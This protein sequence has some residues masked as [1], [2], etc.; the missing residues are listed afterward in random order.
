MHR[1]IAKSGN[2]QRTMGEV[3]LVAVDDDLTVT[4][5]QCSEEKDKIGLDDI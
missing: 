3:A 4:I 1:V 5:Y 2:G